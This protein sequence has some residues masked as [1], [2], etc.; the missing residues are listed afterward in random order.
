MTDAHLS[1]ELD[2]LARLISLLVELL[3]HEVCHGADH[4]HLFVLVVSGPGPGHLL[5]NSHE[6]GL[7]RMTRD[8]AEILAKVVVTCRTV[9]K[10]DSL[11]KLKVCFNVL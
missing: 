10:S 7:A 6:L 11:R 2:I 9:S 3:R 4:G 5:V 1:G 8:V